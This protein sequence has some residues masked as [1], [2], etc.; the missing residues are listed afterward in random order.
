MYLWTKEV[1]KYP[2][3]RINNNSGIGSAEQ[4]V[5]LSTISALHCTVFF[6][7][8][9]TLLQYDET[10]DNA[11]TGVQQQCKHSTS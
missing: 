5:I 3:V 2:T 1:P 9:T 7:R 8:L 6:Y 10:K 11:A 4:T